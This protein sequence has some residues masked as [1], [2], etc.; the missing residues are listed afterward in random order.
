MEKTVS[1]KSGKMYSITDRKFPR[2]VNNIQ[3]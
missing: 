3:F 2:P 1:V